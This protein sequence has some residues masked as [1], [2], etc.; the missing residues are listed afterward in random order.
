VLCSLYAGFPHLFRVLVLPL[1]ITPLKIF[2]WGLL[3]P[4]SPFQVAEIPQS[5]TLFLHNVLSIS[6]LAAMLGLQDFFEL[7]HRQLLFGLLSLYVLNIWQPYLFVW[8]SWMTFAQF[9]LFWLGLQNCRRILK[10]QRTVRACCLS[11]LFMPP[12][13]RLYSELY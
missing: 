11:L 2:L 4:S 7:C 3:G 8:L 13:R 5:P 6:S 1:Y 10:L 9:I 12:A